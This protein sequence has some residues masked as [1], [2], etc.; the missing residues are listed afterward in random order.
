MLNFPF[1]IF[2][3]DYGKTISCDF[4][5]LY[6]FDK[7]A[8]QLRMPPRCFECCLAEVQPS[9]INFS[10]NDWQSEANALLHKAADE[11][12]VIIDVNF[13]HII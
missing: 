3:M 8:E 7:E 2:L 6:R 13:G 5:K 11:Q 10:A 1:Q 9:T 12:D 4:D